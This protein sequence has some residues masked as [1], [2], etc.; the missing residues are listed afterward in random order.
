MPVSAT[1]DTRHIIVTLHKIQTLLRN[2]FYLWVKVLVNSECKSVVME[3]P[4]GDHFSHETCRDLTS[5]CVIWSFIAGE[6]RKKGERETL[7]VNNSF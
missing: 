3:K 2:I 6:E 4:H 7:I 1:P 5:E